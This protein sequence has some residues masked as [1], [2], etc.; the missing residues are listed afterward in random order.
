[1]NQVSG[2]GYL[3]RLQGKRGNDVLKAL[4]ELELVSSTHL[5]QVARL[6]RSAENRAVPLAGTYRAN[7]DIVTLLAAAFARGEVGRPAIP[8]A[9]LET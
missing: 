1:M 5:E 8:Y 2:H 6:R 3:S 7:D 9:R 4:A